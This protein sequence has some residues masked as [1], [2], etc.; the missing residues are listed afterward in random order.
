MSGANRGAVIWK[1][2]RARTAFGADIWTLR[3][4]DLPE[5]FPVE[6]TLE[7]LL[8][9]YAG[10]DAALRLLGRNTKDDIHCTVVW[11]PP[12]DQWHDMRDKVRMRTAAGDVVARDVLE[13]R[14]GRSGLEAWGVWDTSEGW[15]PLPLVVERL[16]RCHRL[17]DEPRISLS[18]TLS[19]NTTVQGC[20]TSR[21]P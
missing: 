11:R 15:V 19:P 14:A 20:P 7:H 13:A 21:K 16:A 3:R 12:L 17:R 18:P 8:W 1:T 4:L 10:E 5:I 9:L 2:E 6:L